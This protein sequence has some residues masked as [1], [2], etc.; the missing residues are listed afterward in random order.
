MTINEAVQ[1]M[2]ESLTLAKG[3]DVFLLDMGQP[4]KI[5]DLAKKMIYLS[6]LSVKD[7]ENQR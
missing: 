1:L 2:I 3:G 7:Q 4:L 5:L 6:G